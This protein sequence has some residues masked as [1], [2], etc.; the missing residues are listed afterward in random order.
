MA[1]MAN[2]E[3]LYSNVDCFSRCFFATD[4]DVDDDDVEG[5]TKGIRPSNSIAIG[6]KLFELSDVEHVFCEGT[7]Q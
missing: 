6:D 7:S 3:T 1:E 2:L 4:V 5:R